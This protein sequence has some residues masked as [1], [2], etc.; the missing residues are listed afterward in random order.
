MQYIRI[1]AYEFKGS[2]TENLRDN[3]NRIKEWHTNFGEV[4]AKKLAKEQQ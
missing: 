2:R 1:K 4:V 3:M